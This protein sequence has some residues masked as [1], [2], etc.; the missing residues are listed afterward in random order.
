M[1]RYL[2]SGVLRT[3]LSPQEGD[4]LSIVASWVEG[5][6]W[7]SA[8][9]NKKKYFQWAI[10][11]LAGCLVLAEICA[12]LGNRDSALAIGALGA[13]AST[14][15]GLVARS[16]RAA[17]Q[18]RSVGRFY[19]GGLALPLEG[20]AVLYDLSGTS[21]DQKLWLR[22]LQAPGE[23]AEITE[24]IRSFL[25]ALNLFEPVQPSL[26][27]DDKKLFGI[28]YQLTDRQLAIQANLANAVTQQ[29]RLPA[30]P[31]DDPALHGI[32]RL[33]PHLREGDA[34]PVLAQ[35]GKNLAELNAQVEGL[36]MRAGSREQLDIDDTLAQLIALSEQMLE[37]LHQAH[38]GSLT[39]VRA[40]HNL[41][42]HTTSSPAFTC[43]CPFCNPFSPDGHELS[44]ATRLIHDLAQDTLYCPV[45]HAVV[46]EHIAIL[47]TRFCDEV[48][49]P[50]FDQIL[51]SERQQILAIERDVENQLV[52]TRKEEKIKVHEAQRGI[53]QERRK[54]QAQLRQHESRA[55]A[56][57]VQVTSITALLAR[58]KKLE[59]QAQSRFDNDARQIREAIEARCSQIEDEIERRYKQLAAIASAE[60]QRRAQINHEE[61]E[62]R[63]RE[64]LTLLE[65]LAET[66]DKRLRLDLMTSE[67]KDAIRY[68]GLLDKINPAKQWRI[69]SANRS[70]RKSSTNLA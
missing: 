40:T 42:T 45:C 24:Q 61:T 19:W 25:G 53:D 27:L 12:L 46:P 41:A 18:V 66:G 39:L 59:E 54:R 70:A 10:G 4:D 58:Y 3:D 1:P 34:L 49:Y 50:V 56:L 32:A 67:Q 2:A 30:L 37:K 17:A 6:L 8:F 35:P 9:I 5:D 36:Y 14:F 48:F 57:Q 68:T 29:V 55:S 20:K 23:L 62:R 47:L 26:M 11:V 33:L 52:Q 15:L 51:L 69:S 38:I 44:R 7:K 16:Q 13:A 21:P 64:Q 43:Y 63:H 22:Q 65:R 31:N 28:D 60:S